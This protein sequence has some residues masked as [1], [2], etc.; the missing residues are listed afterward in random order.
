MDEFQELAV[1]SALGIWGVLTLILMYFVI[2]FIIVLVVWSVFSDMTSAEVLRVMLRWV[3]CKL[4]CG[5]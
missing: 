4:S 3:A 2:L 1:N 5:G